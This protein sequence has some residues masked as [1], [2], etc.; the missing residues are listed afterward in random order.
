MQTKSSILFTLKIFNRDYNSKSTVNGSWLFAT[1]VNEKEFVVY[2]IL[3]ILL[4][5]VVVVV[6]VVVVA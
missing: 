1:P 3:D 5:V 6:V 2:I 4:I